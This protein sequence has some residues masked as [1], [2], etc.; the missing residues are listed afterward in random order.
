M[1]DAIRFYT[2]KTKYIFSP[3]YLSTMDAYLSPYYV[4]A[5]DLKD[6]V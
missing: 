3:V 1:L 5:G 6:R 2:G 4:T